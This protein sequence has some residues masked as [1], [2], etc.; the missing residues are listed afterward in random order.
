LVCARVADTGVRAG[1]APASTRSSKDRD[2]GTPR[3]LVCQHERSPPVEIRMADKTCAQANVSGV[4]LA[5]SS[6][7]E[8]EGG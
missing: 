2:R 7:S 4:I 1:A 5:R 8:V 6:P 3:F